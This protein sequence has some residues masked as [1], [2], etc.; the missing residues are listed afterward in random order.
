MKKLLLEAAAISLLVAAGAVS[1]QSDSLEA[2]KK[3]YDAHC[4]QCHDS[5]KM[6]APVLSDASEWE[7]LTEIPWSEVH[8]LHLEDD[9]LTDAADNP[10][11][12]ITAEQMEAATNYIL[13]IVKKK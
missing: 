8:A 11:K 12:G 2:G 7:G 4:V 13:S 10:A 1:A 6:G 3:V 9:L 5:G